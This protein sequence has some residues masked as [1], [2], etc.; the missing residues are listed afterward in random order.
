MTTNITRGLSSM[1]WM[2]AD[3]TRIVTLEEFKQQLNQD[4]RRIARQIRFVI[5]VTTGLVFLVFGIYISRPRVYVLER[6]AKTSGQIT[7]YVRRTDFVWNASHTSQRTIT[8]YHPTVAF[9]IGG[10]L[11]RFEDWRSVQRFPPVNSVIP[12]VYDPRDPSKA[13]IDRSFWNFIP[14]APITMVG[15]LLFLNALRDWPTN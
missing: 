4:P 1:L 13:M 6:P 10:Q 14:W 9:Q 3:R 2:V 8:S 12:V 5:G 11:I 7:G 15:L